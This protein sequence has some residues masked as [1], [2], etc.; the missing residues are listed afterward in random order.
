MDPLMK[1]LHSTLSLTDEE[2]SIFTLSDSFPTPVDKHPSSL[3]A[4][5]LS[6]QNIYKPSF[7]NQMFG[8]WQA[9]GNVIGEF[10]E[11]FDDSTNEGWGPFLRVRVKLC[12]TKPLLRGQMI[13]LPKIEDEF[14]VNFRYKRLLEFCFECGQIGH[15]FE[16]CVI[17]I[18]RMDN[19]NDDDFQYGPWMKGAK[20][21]TNDYD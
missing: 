3:L 1:N 14:W 2:R 4:R 9:L 12:D 19:G 17:F 18:E 10:M 13:Q 15:T 20:L 16:C 5:V 11:V 8:L 7:I 21:P 6:T